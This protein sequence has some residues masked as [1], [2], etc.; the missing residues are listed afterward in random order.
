MVSIFIDNA[1]KYSN[2]SGTIKIQLKT[3]NGKKIL[4]IYNT[5]IGIEKEKKKDF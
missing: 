4:S 2:E 1:F 3:E 5:G